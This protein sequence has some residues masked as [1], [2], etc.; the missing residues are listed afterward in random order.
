MKKQV[1]VSVSGL[2]RE[3]SKIIDYVF[4]EKK[5]VYVSKRGKIV[6]KIVYEANKKNK[7]TK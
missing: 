2:N 6:A 3:T 5:E 4:S 7:K 1:I